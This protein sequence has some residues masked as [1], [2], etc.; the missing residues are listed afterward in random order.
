MSTRTALWGDSIDYGNGARGAVVASQ[1]CHP[2]AAGNILGSLFSR[3][4]DIPFIS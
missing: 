2:M 3:G 4:Q 1:I